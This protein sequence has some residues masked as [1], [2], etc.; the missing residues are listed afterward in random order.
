M[1]TYIT[2]LVIYIE[3]FLPFRFLMVVVLETFDMCLLW[4]CWQIFYICMH[5]YMYIILFAIYKFFCFFDMCLFWS[6]WQVFYIC[7]HMYMYIIPLA[8]YIYIFSSPPSLE[9]CLLRNIC[10]VFVLVLLTHF[11]YVF[12]CVCILHV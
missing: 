8:I 6:C 3:I 1:Y 5:M 12:V 2:L 4:S 10:Y 9:G 11:L 7:M